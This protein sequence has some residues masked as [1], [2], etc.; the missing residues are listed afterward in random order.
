MFFNTSD[1]AE[2][3]LLSS[4][5]PNGTRSWNWVELGLQIPIF[6]LS[7]HVIEDE[8]TSYG[9]HVL[10]GSLSDLLCAVATQSDKVRIH[11]LQLL[12]PGYMNG[13]ER[14]QIGLVK[15][16][17]HRKATPNYLCVMAD[18]NELRFEPVVLTENPQEMALVLDMGS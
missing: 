4:L 2:H 10:Y 9:H 7:L 14:Y 18:G 17:W 16:I 6:L 12:S 3:R 15:E 8:N 5:V 1:K 11:E 13:G